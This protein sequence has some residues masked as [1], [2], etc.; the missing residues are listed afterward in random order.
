MNRY[1]EVPISFI[2]LKPNKINFISYGGNT[3]IV[4][5]V[6]KNRMSLIECF[7][8]AFYHSDSK[9]FYSENMGNRFYFFFNW[10]R[11]TSFL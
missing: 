5:T 11:G 9:L 1:L 3:K 6:K 4:E 2:K 10:T 8:Y 7:I